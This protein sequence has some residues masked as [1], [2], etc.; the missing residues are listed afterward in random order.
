MLQVA[1]DSGCRYVEAPGEIVDIDLSSIQR[2]Q[3]AGVTLLAPHR[4]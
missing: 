3:Q 2:V 4:H 1:P